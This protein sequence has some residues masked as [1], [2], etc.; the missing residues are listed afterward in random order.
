MMSDTRKAFITRYLASLKERSRAEASGTKWGVDWVAYNL[1]LVLFGKPVRLPFIRQAGDEMA[2]SKDGEAEFGVDVSFLSTDEKQLVVLVLK[3]E[4][5]T[6]K[7]WFDAGFEKDLRRATYPD[8]DAAGLE[9]LESVRIILAYNSDERQTGVEQY[10]R[11]VGGQPTTLRDSIN[12]TYERWNLSEL[13][14]LT[15]KHLLN[16]AL[17]PQ[18]FFGQLT[19][20]SAQF[21]ELEHGSEAWEAQ[22][23]PGWHRFVNDVLAQGSSERGVALLPVA[24]IIL[25]EHG[26]ANKSFET[27]WIELVEIAALA[28]WKKSLASEDPQ[29]QA[30]VID[31]W[32]SFYI[33]ELFRFYSTHIEALATEN[34]I[35][36]IA[37]AAYVGAVAA[38]AMAHWHLGRIGILAYSLTERRGDEEEGSNKARRAASHEISNWVVRLL[39]AN[40]SGYRPLL[41]IHHIEW[42]LATHTLVRAGRAHEIKP[43]L[44]EL[45]ER[46]YLRRTEHSELPFLD[47]SN[48]L[49]NVFEHVATMGEDSQIVVGSS[50][51]VLMLL[52]LSFFM[53]TKERA[54]MVAFIHSH[55]V[56]GVEGDGEDAKFKDLHLVSWIPPSDWTSK[57][58]D[59]TV[60]D[61]EEVTIGP[62]TN[63]RNADGEVIANGLRSLVQQMRATSD[64][65]EQQPVPM[66]ALIL[67]CIRY[68]SPLP[69][70]LW[71]RHAFPEE[72]FEPVEV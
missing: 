58:L 43:L 9:K 14:D 44:K 57:V 60:E 30:R 18:T 5:L 36:Q 2:K 8:L 38:G 67:A 51:F 56:L 68:R 6:Y 32:N 17:L 33:Q 66:A 3:D 55:L 64:F 46:L 50:A 45:A 65:P 24:L 70:E 12:L 25:R 59:G 13:V 42:F 16:P 40:Q 29:L 10:D 52:E 21:S 49:D 69:P 34:A 35:D 31:F 72:K 27:G 28:M 15:L 63:D 23:V 20:L 53:P 71:R 37:G 61:G 1:G 19:Y 48:S 47:G 62:F 7:N 4:E 54:A 41:D 22:L 39:N 11:F 26:T